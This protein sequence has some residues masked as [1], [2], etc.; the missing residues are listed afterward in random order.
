MIWQNERVVGADSRAGTVEIDDVEFVEELGAGGYGRVFKGYNRRLNRN[1]A[2]KVLDAV[3]DDVQREQ[4]DVECK[5]HG[6]LSDHQNIVTVYRAGYTPSSQPYLEMEYVEQGSL[7]EHLNQHGPV[8]WRQAVEWML[9]ICDAV[10]TA[11]ARGILHRDLKPANILLSASGP[12]LADFGIA[13][14]RDDA[15]PVHALS[16]QHAPPEALENQTDIRSDVYSLASTLYQL[17][18]GRPPMTMPSTDPAAMVRV[19]TEAP[20]P[21]LPPAVAPDWLNDLLTE[22]LAKRPGDRPQAIA[23]LAQRLRVGLS[24]SVRAEGGSPTEAVVPT[25]ASIGSDEGVAEPKEVGVVASDDGPTP[26]F[27]GLAPVPVK[28]VRRP[29]VLALVSAGLVAVLALAVLAAFLLSSDTDANTG[30]VADAPAQSTQSAEEQVSGRD[31]TAGAGEDGGQARPAQSDRDVDP[32]SGATITTPADDADNPSSDSSAGSPSTASSTPGSSTPGSSTP[33]S[34][35]PGTSTPGTST[36]GTSSPSTSSPGTSAPPD[37]AISNVAVEVTVS[38]GRVT[39]TTNECSTARYVLDGG[40]QVHTAPG[41]PDA[42]VRCWTSHGH[43]FTQLEPDT[44]YVAQIDV[45][46]AD[47]ASDTVEAVRFRTAPVSPTDPLVVVP[48]SG[49]EVVVGETNSWQLVAQGGSGQ[50]TWTGLRLPAGF[51]LNAGGLLQFRPTAAG[52]FSVEVRVT[53]LVSQDSIDAT[54]TVTALPAE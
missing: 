30:S 10:E 42:S 18:A 52:P 54:L 15:D 8:P 44:A 9:P 50:F 24:E 34:S 16:L 1:V 2:V 51:S 6:P 7:L 3:V 4:F 19:I 43:T 45:R 35:T 28:P 46:S 5:H 41:W 53:D 38:T 31:A 32:S 27:S 17:V 25:T 33:D 29:S 39:F 48:P 21:R 14:L 12:K 22:A 47:G 26:P 49:A 37:V 11:H 23:D 13:C 36:P 20:V 40:D